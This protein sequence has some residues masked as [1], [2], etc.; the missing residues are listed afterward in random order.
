[1][2]LNCWEYKKCGRQPGG[3][4]VHELGVC[5]ASVEA[6]VDG[7][8]GGKNGGRTCWVMTGTLCKGEKQ[9]SFATKLMSCMQCDFYKSVIAEEGKDFVFADQVLPK[10][11]KQTSDNK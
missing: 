7:V 1:M 9:G 2:K 4:K 6:R 5:P 11:Y 8:N 3:D 10:L